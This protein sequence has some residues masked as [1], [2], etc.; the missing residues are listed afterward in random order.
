M[1][2]LVFSMLSKTKSPGVANIEADDQRSSQTVSESRVRNING[3][4]MLPDLTFT[5]SVF[6]ESFSL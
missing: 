3:H 4:A 5:T 1:C 6:I 2:K